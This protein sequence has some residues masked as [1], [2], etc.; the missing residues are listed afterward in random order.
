MFLLVD[1]LKTTFKKI[2][3]EK[4][5]SFMKLHTWAKSSYDTR[6]DYMTKKDSIS[7]GL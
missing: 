3:G 5:P 6:L 7:T 2:E 4:K 1:A